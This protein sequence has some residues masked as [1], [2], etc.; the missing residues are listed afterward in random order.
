MK[1]AVLTAGGVGSRTKQEIPKQFI[2]VD[3]KPLIIYA[4][5]AF[6]KHPEIDVIGIACLEGWQ[7]V[8]AAYARQ[9]NITKLKHIVPAGKNGQESIYNVLKEFEKNYSPS[10]MV[11][12]HDGVR[13]MVSQEMISDCIVT[14][15]K[16]GNAIASVPTVEAVMYSKDGLESEEYYD[17]TKLQRTQTPHAWLME[18][19]LD[20]HR[21]ALSKGINDTVASCTMAVDLGKKVYFSLGS[22]KNL[23]VTS[24]EDFEI[25]KALLHVGRK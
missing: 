24:L 10:D 11:L 8:L 23:K 19:I 7:D 20:M 1:L 6:Q 21:T 13:P 16:Y 9:Y 5:E 3:D 22:E 14:A 2:H 15:E 4:L 25:F 17:R 18:D 12:I